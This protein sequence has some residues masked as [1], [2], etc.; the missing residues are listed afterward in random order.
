MI[1]MGFLSTLGS[2]LPQCYDSEEQV[3]QPS[4]LTSDGCFQTHVE[5]PIWR[6]GA[7][8]TSYPGAVLSFVGRYCYPGSEFYAFLNWSSCLTRQ[9][10]CE[11]DLDTLTGKEGGIGK[12]WA[13][14]IER[15]QKRDP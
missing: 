2:T 8:A 3:P 1:P 11:E 10:N 14:I 7:L 12:P 6:W 15:K 5:D 13:S 9:R 4:V